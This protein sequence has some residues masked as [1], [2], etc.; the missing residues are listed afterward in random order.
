MADEFL[1]AT[2]VADDRTRLHGHRLEQ[3][4]AQALVPGRHG[5]N[6]KTTG[7]AAT[8]GNETRQPQPPRPSWI[9]RTFCHGGILDGADEQNV[10]IVQIEALDGSIEK[11]VDALDRAN[12]GDGPD[13]ECVM[14]NAESLPYRVTILWTE[15]GPV[16]AVV[17]DVACI[18]RDS[19]LNEPVGHRLRFAGVGYDPAGQERQ[20]I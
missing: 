19:C 7:Q 4:P 18:A 8:R 13:H 12:R 9:P 10:K 5:K 11:D 6:V 1:H 15:S 14:G 16:D 2:G 17:D 20:Q 3:C